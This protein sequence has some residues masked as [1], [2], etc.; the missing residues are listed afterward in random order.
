MERYVDVHLFYKLAK[1]G[2]QVGTSENRDMNEKAPWT[3]GIV[4]NMTRCLMFERFMYL[5][6]H[7]DAI[8]GRYLSYKIANEA[9]S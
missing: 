1:L 4:L 6:V 8:K 7:E 5:I 9:P 3:N 2:H